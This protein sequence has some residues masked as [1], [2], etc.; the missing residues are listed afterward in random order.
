MHNPADLDGDGHVSAWEALALI[1]VG[2]GVFFGLGP[3]F[4]KLFGGW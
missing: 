2:T 4:L 1:A 3:L